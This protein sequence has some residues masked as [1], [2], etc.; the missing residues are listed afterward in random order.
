VTEPKHAT[1]SPS[2]SRIY[3]WRDERFHSV[4]TIIGGGIP[5]PVLVNW[6]KKF[7]A[8]Y[9]VDNYK[10]LG[11][12]LQPDDAGDV[13]R[14]GAIDWLKNASFRDRDRKAEMGTYLH[15][16]TEAYILGKP[17]PAWPPIVKPRMQ[18][19]EQ[20]L[21]AYEPTYE[22]TEQSV[23]SR[24]ERY[25]GTLD[26][27]L[28]VGRGPHKGRRFIADMKSG[29]GVYPEVALQLA[30]YRYAEFIGLPDGSEAPMVPVD[31]AVALHLPEVGGFDLIDVQADE[32]IFR[33]FKYVRE[34]YRWTSVM[35]KSVL[36]GTL[37][38]DPPE[39]IVLFTPEMQ[40]LKQ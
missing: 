17:F 21:A 11:A 18:A 34:V 37:R 29:K 27:I 15:A 28:T 10:R 36:Q 2:G 33:M 38:T 25:A 19:F 40:G 4:T 16:A 31:G 39:E 26:A 35:A 12:L 22:M 1:T 5:K 32:E 6:A 8:E 30:A 13:D 3:T 14:Q 23:F 24:A 9:A 20:Y 7:T